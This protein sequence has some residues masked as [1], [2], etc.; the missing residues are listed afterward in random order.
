MW[1]DLPFPL[2]RTI[3]QNILPRMMA[4]ALD[5]HDPAAFLLRAAASD[6]LLDIAR[7]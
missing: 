7:G 4:G 6:R 5:E 1:R 2:D 3:S